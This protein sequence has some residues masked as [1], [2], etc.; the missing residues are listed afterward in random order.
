MTIDL[1]S[2]LATAEAISAVMKSRP[3][4]MLVTDEGAAR[5]MLGI[6]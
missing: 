6:D 3:H 5:A 4:A 1:N 2:R